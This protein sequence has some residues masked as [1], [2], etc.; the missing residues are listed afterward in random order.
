MLYCNFLFPEGR[1][2]ALTMSYDDGVPEDRRL[3]EIFNRYGIRGTFHLNSGRQGDSTLEDAAV[4]Y[5]GHEV[6]CH[7]KN[8][9]SLDRIPGICVLQQLLEDRQKLESLVGY[10]VRGL[11][12]PNGAFNTEILPRLSNVGIVYSRTTISTGHFALPD[13]WLR[14]NPTCHHNDDLAGKAERFKALKSALNVFYVWGHSYEFERQKTWERI[15]GFCH[16]ISG[17]QDIWYATNIEIYDYM[18]AARNLQFSADGTLVFNP[19]CRSVWLNVQGVIRE[20][21]GGQL[22]KLSSPESA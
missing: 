16:D 3:V 20:I 8:H 7:S 14:W 1:L 22:E 9:F 12:Y 4:L 13:D 2:K 11:S 21:P 6:S 10:P 15:E 5:Q 17:Q 19:S 18:Q